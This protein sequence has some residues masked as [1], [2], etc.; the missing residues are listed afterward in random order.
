[1]MALPISSFYDQNRV[2]KGSVM[3]HS[4]I[5]TS[6]LPPSRRQLLALTVFVEGGM[7]LLALALGAMFGPSTKNVLTL[8]ASHAAIGA[9]AGLGL[10]VLAIGFVNSPIGR[11]TQ[12]RRDIDQLVELFDNTRPVDLILMSALAGIGE[13]AL[14]RGLLLYH[15]AEWMNMPLALAATSLLFGLMHAVSPAYIVFTTLLGLAM[16]GLYLW[17]GNLLV[18]IVAHGVYDLAALVHIKYRHRPAQSEQI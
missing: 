10:L 18:P 16:G 15:G 14:F 6:Q 17:Y 12:L 4:D 11:N 2:L 5:S 9:L 8:S 7:I 3:A 1:M 13:E